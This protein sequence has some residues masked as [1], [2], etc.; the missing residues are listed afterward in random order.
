MIHLF[1]RI[2]LDLLYWPMT[3][4]ICGIIVETNCDDLRSSCK[5][6]SDSM[7]IIFVQILIA[8]MDHTCKLCSKCLKEEELKK[9]RNCCCLRAAVQQT[10]PKSW[11]IT[12]TS[13]M[14]GGGDTDIKVAGVAIC[15][16]NILLSRHS[17]RA[18]SVSWMDM[19]MNVLMQVI[20]KD[21]LWCWL[22]DTPQGN[23]KPGF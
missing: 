13:T 15:T 3:S 12:I 9:R 14:G 10:A 16:T 6:R 17:L 20:Q 7:T 22:I 11:K 1:F 19:C 5:C 21:E 4:Q 8:R 18:G 23:Q 2:K